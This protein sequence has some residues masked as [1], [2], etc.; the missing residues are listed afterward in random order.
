[1]LGSKLESKYRYEN[2]AV[3]ALNDGGV[4]VGAQIAAQL[5]CVLTM[6]LVSEMSLP[7]ENN[8]FG[9]LTSEGNF[10]YNPEYS[11]GEIDELE[12]EFRNVIEQQKLTKLHDMN[13]LLGSGGLIRKDLLRGHNVILVADGL[14]GGG[15]LNAAN[16][17][18]KPIAVDRLIVAT[19]L[20]DVKALD[21]IHVMADEIQCLNVIEGD[22]GVNHYYEKNDIPNHRK[23]VET[24][25]S[26]VLHWK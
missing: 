11:Q 3:V 19:P 20:A 15:L 26:I 10:T 21:T 22:F 12:G 17:F 13:A 2:C 4:V 1:M 6:L 18:L 9:S 24:I 8:S 23:I 16:L 25:E 14:L 7:R 5:H